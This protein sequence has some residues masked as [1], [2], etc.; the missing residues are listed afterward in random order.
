MLCRS[1]LSFVVDFTVL[2]MQLVP[3]AMAWR[4][5]SELRMAK[6]SVRHSSSSS[7]STILSS[8][9]SRVSSQGGS[10]HPPVQRSSG[11]P[12]LLLAPAEGG[13]PYVH[14][15]R[16]GSLDSGLAPTPASVS[17]RS[18]VSAPLLPSRPIATSSIVEVSR[19]A[20]RVLTYIAPHMLRSHT[21]T[22]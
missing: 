1:V 21:C 4:E 8:Y 13:G 16:S 18:T 11:S 7:S 17:P 20:Q 5:L 19:T 14:I 10:P 2:M 22:L 3:P 6:Q 9:C 15:R 12:P